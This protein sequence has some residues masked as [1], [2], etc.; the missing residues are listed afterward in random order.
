MPTFTGLGNYIHSQAIIVIGIIVTFVAV[1]IIWKKAWITGITII[2][3]IAFFSAFAN[4]SGL[5]T[6]LSSAI[7]ALFG[8]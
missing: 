3:S 4:N 1:W 5:V 6:K 7:T 2:V 8:L